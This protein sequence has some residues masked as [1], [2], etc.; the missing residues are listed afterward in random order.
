MSGVTLGPGL[1]KPDGL[2]QNGSK[3][4]ERSRDGRMWSRRRA[5]RTLILG[6]VS[7]EPRQEGLR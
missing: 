1:G 4:L 6:S 7:W 3:R 5:G 2:R